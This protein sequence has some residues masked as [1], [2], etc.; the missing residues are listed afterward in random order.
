[1]VQIYWYNTNSSP[2]GS[3]IPKLRCPQGGSASGLVLHEVVVLVELS[4]L[5]VVSEMIRRLK[6]GED[7]LDAKKKDPMEEAD[8]R[9]RDARTIA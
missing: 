4:R 1:V 7:R 5:Q 6:S 8:G 3:R 9:A 2:D